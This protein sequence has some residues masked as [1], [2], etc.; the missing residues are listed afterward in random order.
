[1]N[2]VYA[3][4]VSKQLKITHVRNPETET[5]F[6]LRGQSDCDAA[7]VDLHRIHAV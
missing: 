2:E 6:T 7:P 4:R 3:R 5:S 1:M